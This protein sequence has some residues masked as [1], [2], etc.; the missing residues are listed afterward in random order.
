M[1]PVNRRRFLKSGTAVTAAGLTGIAGCL[2]GDDGIPTLSYHFTVPIENFASLLGIPEIQEELE[3][4]GEEYELTVSNDSSTID[5]LNAMA[6]GEC[7]I[8]QVTTESY[9][10]AIM[11]DAVPQGITKIATD[12]WDAHDDYYGFTV[13]SPPGSDLTEP[14]DMEGA[15]LGINAINTGIH[16]TYTR[17]LMDLGLDPE[18][19]VEYVEQEFGAL[20]AAAEDG[21]VDAIVLP[22]LFAAGVRDEFNA[23]YTSHEVFDQ[24]YPFAYI[25]AANRAL[26]DHEDAI[27]TWAEDYVDIIDYVEENRDEVVSLAADHFEV[28]EEQIDAFYLTEHDYYRGVYEVDFDALQFAMDELE[29]SGITDDSFDVEDHATNEYLP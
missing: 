2:G 12:F 15:N 26:E 16:A 23:V 27:R 19:D 17:K 8:A 29:E 9:A 6:A 28:P 5:S 18:E 22:P 11:E 24:E 21:I 10:N 3:N 4:V 1:V 13:Y 20:P 25:A 7:D 14:E